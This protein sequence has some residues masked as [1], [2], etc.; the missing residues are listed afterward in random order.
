MLHNHVLLS[1]LYEDSVQLTKII[2]NRK[3]SAVKSWLKDQCARA[4][5]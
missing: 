4:H 3:K 5:M 1:T 2:K